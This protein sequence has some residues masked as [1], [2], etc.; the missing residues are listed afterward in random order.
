[1]IEKTSAP[2]GFDGWLRRYV[3]QSTTAIGLVVGVTGVM[4]FFHLARDRVESAHEWLGV[5]FVL[6]AVLHVVRHRRGFVQMLRERRQHA[7]FALAGLGVAGFLLASGGGHDG[8]SV[9]R[10]ADRAMEVPLATLAPL[11]GIKADEAVLR[12]L[13]GG[14]SGAQPGQS[15]I[16]LAK[17]N[18]VEPSRLLALVLGEAAETEE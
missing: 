16:S 3:T 4:M 15:L 12:L 7:L 18:H 1:M 10:L 9:H 14:I 5:I 2:A 17:A 13:A 11:V 8:P 6:F